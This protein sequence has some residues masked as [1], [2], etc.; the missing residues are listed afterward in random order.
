MSQDILGGSL[1]TLED[2]GFAAAPALHTWSHC[3]GAVA[4]VGHF[5]Q[6]LPERDAVPIGH[7]LSS[8][9]GVPG[10]FRALVVW[11]RGHQQSPSP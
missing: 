1:C 10:H 9:E 2:I 6:G 7:L 3:I 5:A 4:P 11:M 8:R